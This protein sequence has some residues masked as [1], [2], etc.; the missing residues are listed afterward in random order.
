M[1]VAKKMIRPFILW[2]LFM[3]TATTLQWFYFALDQHFIQVALLQGLLAL[4]VMYLIA[5]ATTISRE[6]ASGLVAAWLLGVFGYFG[7]MDIYMDM[8]LRLLLLLA[9]AVALNVVLTLVLRK[10]TLPQS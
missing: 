7:A 8:R 6:L 2:L 3:V 9:I 10:R 5:R 4:A 1:S